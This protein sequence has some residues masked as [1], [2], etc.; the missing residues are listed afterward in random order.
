[1]LPAGGADE[2]PQS[3]HVMGSLHL[4]VNHTLF[5]KMKS[6]LCLQSWDFSIYLCFHASVV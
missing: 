1:M 5:S 4:M 2:F 6:F 3:S